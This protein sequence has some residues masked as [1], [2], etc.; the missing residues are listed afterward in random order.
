MI[1][2]IVHMVNRCSGADLVGDALVEDEERVGRVRHI[3]CARL[4][5][6]FESQKAT[7]SAELLLRRSRGL[8]GLTIH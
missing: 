3:A 2:T 7:K 4:W 1:V 6:L 5:L 8:N